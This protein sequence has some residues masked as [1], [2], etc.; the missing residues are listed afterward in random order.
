M[1]LIKWEQVQIVLI[2][3]TYCLWQ[4]EL[5]S[6]YLTENTGSAQKSFL[7]AELRL[8]GQTCIETGPARKLKLG[9][10]GR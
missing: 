9:L 5:Q 6:L 10:K 3:R 1:G 8:P 2:L 7:A 4:A